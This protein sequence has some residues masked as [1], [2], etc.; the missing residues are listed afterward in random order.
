M[1][2][3]ADGPSGG[4]LVL[5][6]GR[7]IYASSGAA[8][9][10]DLDAAALVGRPFGDL[11]APE[12]RERIADRIARRAR[13]DP[14]PD[15]YEVTLVLP[16]GARRVVEAR[17]ALDGADLVLDLRDVSALAARRPRL[18]AIAHLG[19]EILRELDEGR[20]WRRARAGLRAAGLTTVLMRAEEACV[21][22]EWIDVPGDAAKRPEAAGLSLVGLAIPWTE[23]SRSAWNEGGV[24]SDD[25]LRQVQV[26][27]PDG[28]AERARDAAAA[29]GLTRAVAVRVDERAAPRFYLV[30]AADWL[31][32]EDL[33]AFRLL[34]A[35]VGSAL[36]AAR[37]VAGLA[38]HNADLAAL[39]RLGELSS[40]AA[41]LESFLAEASRTVRREAACDGVA[42]FTVADGGREL[43]LR[44]QEGAEAGTAAAFARLPVAGALAEIL[45]ARAPVAAT[46][47]A[48][49]PEHRERLRPL[50]F[51]TNAWVPLYTRSGPAG[52]MALGWREEIAPEAVRLG[53]LQAA[54]AHIAAALESHRLL[55]DLRGRVG[56]LTLLNRLALGTATLDPAALLEA[57][58]GPVCETFDADAAGAFLL[59]GDELALAA[60]LGL[61]SLPAGA[62]LRV[63]EGISGRSV[64]ERATVVASDPSQLAPRWSEV[65]ARGGFTRFASAP[66]LSKGRALGS[67]GLSRRTE[68]DFSGEEVALLSTIGAQLGVAVDNARLYRDLAR[69]YEDLA[70]AQSQLVHR[71]RLAALGELAAV[72]AHEVRNP[73]G[74]IF[75]SLG[76]LRRLLRPSG[77]AA[78]LLEIVDEEAAR[79]NRIVADLLDFARP[80]AP[81]IPPEPLGRVVEDAIAAA[82]PRRTARVSL[83]R[84]EEEG[85]PPVPVD[86]RLVRQAVVNLVQNAVQAMPEGGH[87][88]ARVARAPDPGSVL[89]EIED[90]GPGIPEELRGRVFVPF[91]TTRASGTGLG[92]AVVKRIMEFH[93]GEVSLRGTPGGGATFALRFP[94]ARTP[95]PIR[96][97]A[98]VAA[99]PPMG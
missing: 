40:E 82:L 15:R 92:L 2:L 7:V 3:E 85:L 73:L 38:R 78:M 80:S 37:T 11:I 70:R 54:G 27:M 56:E 20:I 65:A 66:L 51:A 87:I 64:A 28:L 16:G 96:P 4:T 43:V 69:S 88:R 19:A 47:S 8:A 62:R 99:G 10:A 79:L 32:A 42:V 57:A 98:P 63:G 60:Q 30:A 97:E 33:P 71:E 34:G 23:F 52:L 72:V 83:V 91:F 17:V 55:E 53:F 5:R 74:V 45:N 18:A 50:G 75:N 94:L 86:A 77:D 67:L 58:L 35:Q 44:F 93:G 1:P 13:G 59:E 81:V 46:T 12:E 89:V 25:W 31:R 61:E 26:V 49:A 29:V 76:S 90:D 41:S 6:D 95:A 21:R 14:A 39:N 22:V 84:E 24:F 68:R 9:L 36:D 48:A